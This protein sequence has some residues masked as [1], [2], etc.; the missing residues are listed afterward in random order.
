MFH[1]DFVSDQSHLLYHFFTML[2]L[3]VP[4]CIAWFVGAK[5]GF[6][7]ATWL[8]TL[9]VLFG[10]GIIGMRLGAFQSAEW[11]ALFYKG[12]W[13]SEAPKTVVGGVVLALLGFQ[14]L[15]R[16]FLLPASAADAIILGMPLGAAIGRLGCLS[17]G[18]CYG[19]S[20][21]GWWSVTFGPASSAFEAQVLS[22]KILA[23]AAETL[24][25]HPVQLDLMLANLLVFTCL[26]IFRKKFKP[27]NLAL[28]GF[29]MM[30]FS[31]F[32]TE[33]FRDLATNRGATGQ[34]FLG[35]KAVQWAALTVITG[36]FLTWFFGK[37]KVNAADPVLTEQPFF[38]MAALI[39][40]LSVLLWVFRLRL[41]VLETL[42]FMFTFT[43]AIAVVLVELWRKEK[44]NW[45][46][47]PST[48][49]LSGALAVQLIAQADSIIVPTPLLNQPQKPQKTWWEVGGGY[50]TQRFRDYDASTTG[51][52]CDAQTHVHRN[53]EVNTKS[54]GL[55][56]AYHQ[57]MGERH[58]AMGGRF[59]F[60]RAETT[61]GFPKNSGNLVTGGIFGSMEGRGL[62]GSLG[63]L[64][65]SEKAEDLLGDESSS[66]KLT[67]GIRVGFPRKYS[68]DV[69]FRERQQFLFYPAPALTVG[70]FNW[71]FNDPTG[72]TWL[73]F[74][75]GQGFKQGSPLVFG[76]FRAPLW[77]HRM[78]VEGGFYGNSAFSIGMKYHLPAKK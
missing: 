17:A 56:G 32:G 61:S 25:L 47:W 29:A 19:T 7:A 30:A 76:A 50:A 20:G 18:C 33:F 2:S 10:L 63:F 23:D 13:V 67:G 31:R 78:S 46:K 6:P 14:F 62:G 37:K 66:I 53:R 3:V 28:A 60:S 54:V 65:A 1:I 5:K 74:G 69:Q 39:F 73:R 57:L 36:C 52:G 77:R 27:G 34:V 16:W 71:G 35:L 72:Q 49:L 9:G 75:V 58:T 45:I 26:L 38:R 68:F 21:G 8:T 43:P 70:L 44:R 55:E 51:S 59:N 24:P 4:F 15:K 22:G 11:A 12:E 40:P 41:G 64:I 42:V 48:A